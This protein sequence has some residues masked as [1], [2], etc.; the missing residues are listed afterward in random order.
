MRV[1]AMG[2]Y[3]DIFD[4]GVRKSLD[5]L[6]EINERPCVVCGETG[7]TLP[8]LE[9]DKLLC[10]EHMAESFWCAEHAPVRN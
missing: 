7:D 2:Y 4:E 8:C 9:C 10:G 6:D 3:L 5:A 1:R